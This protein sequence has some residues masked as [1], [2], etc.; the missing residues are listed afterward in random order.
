MFSIAMLSMH[1]CPV[2]S[3]GERDTGGMNVYVRE[4]SRH[5]GAM[6]IPVDIFT[7]RHS[8]LD[9]DVVT[10]GHNVR[11]I[12]LDGGPNETDLEG[13]YPYV[14]PFTRN[15][16]RFQEGEG[17]AYSLIHSHYWLSALVGRYLARKNTV[18]HVVTFH[19]L[20]ELKR[21]ARAGEGEP[22]F[23]TRI[24]GD[25]TARLSQWFPL[26]ES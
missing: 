7:R 17:A 11:V 8:N 5:L 19:T 13:L 3:P 9:T 21:R 1:G 24:E 22:L 10:V 15:I 4:L 25:L 20:A 23:R 18:S 6:G 12:H 14:Y 26:F 2:A 16:C